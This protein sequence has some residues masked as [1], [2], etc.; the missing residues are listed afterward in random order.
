MNYRAQNLHPAKFAWLFQKEISQKYF[1]MAELS[2]LKI[3]FKW[4]RTCC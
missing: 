1:E 3:N 4:H 2:A